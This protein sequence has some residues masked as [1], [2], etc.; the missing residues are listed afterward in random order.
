MALHWHKNW[1]SF[2]CSYILFSGNAQNLFPNYPPIYQD[3]VVARID[4]TLPPDSLDLILAPGNEK[5]DYPFHAHFI[6]NNGTIQDTFENVGFQLRGNTSRNAAKKSFQVSLNSYVPGRDWYGVEKLDL[7]GEHNDPTISRSKLC[8]DLLRDVGVPAPRA[9]HVELYINQEYFGVYANIE[10][11][12]EEFVESRFGNKDGNLYKCLWPADLTYLGSDP[13][14]YKIQS[15][16]RRVYELKTNEEADDYTDL[17]QFIDI[18]NH[19]PI[20]DLQCELEGVINVHTLLLCMAFDVMT[21]NW[22][23]PLYNKNNFFLYHNTATGLFEYIPYDLDNTFGIDW[24]GVD[25]SNRNIYSWGH[26]SQ[27]RPL[28]SRMLQVPAFK[29]MYSYYL[30]K[31]IDEVYKESVLFPHLDSLKL[32][33]APYVENDLYYTLDYGF[34]IDDFNNGFEQSVPYAHV[35]K[36]IK[37]FIASRK[38]ATKQQLQLME[39]PPVIY[40]LT[41]YPSS[42]QT[43]YVTVAVEDD[44]GIDLVEALIQINTT[45]PVDHF[46][47]L[48]DGL[49][50]DGLAGDKI[51]GLILPSPD[52]CDVFEYSIKAKDIQGNESKY[53]VCGSKLLTICNSALSLAVNELMASNETIEAD[54]FGEYEDWVEIYNYGAEPVYLGDRYLSDKAD[55]PTKWKFPEI[56]IQPGEYLRIWADEDGA[57]GDLHA[58][59][60]LSAAGEYIGIYDSDVNGNALIDGIEFGEQPTDISFGR[61]PNG[62]GPFQYL[63]PTP[64]A[65]NEAISFV[66]EGLPIVQYQLYPNPAHDMVWIKADQ[67]LKTNHYM[68]VMD[69]YGKVLLSKSFSEIISLDVSSLPAAIY[70]VCFKN[71]GSISGMRKLVKE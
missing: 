2:L 14:L 63:I 52:T 31:M 10:H 17:A 44:Q 69:V 66:E 70:I 38:S 45:G 16:D 65:M 24:F 4:I 41:N 22:D 40:N 37:P 68:E 28:Y 48:D 15:G 64:G 1:F 18:L 27:P 36:G 9:S 57:Q 3:D 8:W 19:A 43:R 11:I 53:P 12:D 30:D 42:S 49:H 25:W 29:A 60:K 21:G 47:M 58:N 20:A 23:G 61:L 32:L 39:I 46:Q 62:S 13:D 55:N 59:F 7:N 34:S 33:L 67:T 71:H 35:T 5:S 26:Q 6:F 51:Y 56:S 54:E 50:E